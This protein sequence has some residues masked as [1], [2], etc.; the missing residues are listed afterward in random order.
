MARIK[1]DAYIV[2]DL[3]GAEAA[4]LEIAEL[5]RKVRTEEAIMNATIDQAKARH[6]AESEPLKER[7]KELGN[8]LASFAELNKAELF[9]KKRSLDLGFGVIGFRLAHTLRTLPRVTWE[10]VLTRL[11]ELGF[12]QAIRIKEEVNKEELRGWPEERLATV[13]ARLVTADEFYI[14]INQERLEEAA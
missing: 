13:G 10:M 12:S 6:R 2:R 8:A 4:L 7:R 14:E 3:K 1:P 5:D 11:R 9:G